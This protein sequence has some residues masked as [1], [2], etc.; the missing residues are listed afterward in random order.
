MMGITIALFGL[1]GTATGSQLMMWGYKSP[2]TYIIMAI[3]LAYGAYIFMK[4]MWG[5]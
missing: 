5:K 3:Y 4:V 2:I 1:I